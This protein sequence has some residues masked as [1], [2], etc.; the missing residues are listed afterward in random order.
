MGPPAAPLLSI[1]VVAIGAPRVAAVLRVVP[2][3]L[4]VV[5]GPGPQVMDAGTLIGDS[6]A[7]GSGEDLG[8]IAA[9]MLDVTSGR[10]A[11]GVLS[12]GGFLGMGDHVILQKRLSKTNVRPSRAKIID[13]HNPRRQSATSDSTLG[14]SPT[15]ERVRDASCD[16]AWNGARDCA[17][18]DPS[19]SGEAHKTLMIASTIS[20]TSR[21]PSA[22]LG[23]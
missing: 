4:G 3:R 2:I 6:V 21:A 19:S 13:E 17:E 23:K 1:D 10:I 9:I 12:F 22:P 20:T 15:R 8:K 5:D 14:A 7:D 16:V 18:C 11:Y